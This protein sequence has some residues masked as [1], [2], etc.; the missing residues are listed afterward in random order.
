[1][2]RFL[3]I[4]LLIVTVG[5]KSQNLYKIEFKIKGWKDTTV[6]LGHYYGESTLL[7]DT[8]VVKNEQFV[9]D[10]KDKL[11]QGVYFLVLDKTKLFDFVVG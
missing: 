9:F 10:G 1:M 5:A 7:R 2:K 6:Y 4:I 8:A 11:A 3:F